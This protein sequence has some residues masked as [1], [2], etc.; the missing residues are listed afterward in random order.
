MS[1]DSGAVRLEHRGT[2]AVITF[3]RPSA[4]NAMTW[5]MY[6]ALDDALDR[7]AADSALRVV[8]L[9]GAGGH[10]VAGTDIAQFA[11][12]KS[13]DDGVE[14]ERR[15]EL[16]LT[17][18]ESLPV[19]TIAAVDGFCVGGGLA[20]AA[21]CDVRLCTPD[22]RFGVPIARTVGNCLS[23]ANYARLVA[24]LGA[25]RTKALLFTADFMSGHDAHAAGFVADVID[26]GRF[27]SEVDALAAR[28]ATHAPITL[29]VTREA[30]RRLVSLSAVDGDDLVRRAYAS[31]DFRE[32][33]AAFVEKRSPR[34]EGR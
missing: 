1:A 4:R 20:L 8:V 27:D 34:W 33:V 22:A 13:G 25:S 21:V 9:R 30:V 26:A 32:G 15:L 24:N 12:F 31:H 19:A 7:V 18:L 29:Q 11:G 6:E 2:R 16:V 14:Y 17:K 23:V 5:G 3:D 10:F 28:I